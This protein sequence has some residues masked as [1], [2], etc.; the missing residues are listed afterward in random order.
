M[1]NTNKRS[2]SQSAFQSA[3]KDRLSAA[4]SYRSTS[5]AVSDSIRELKERFNV[6]GYCWQ[7]ADGYQAARLD[8]WYRYN[9]CF[10]Y[11]IGGEIVEKGWDAMTEEQRE[12]CR[13]GKNT[14]G[15]HWWK[16][17]EGKPAIGFPFF[18]SED[19]RL[20][21]D[22]VTGHYPLSDVVTERFTRQAQAA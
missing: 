13:A 5:V 20:P 12:Y 7:W 3:V 1:S 22:P 4:E 17:R 14:V 18:V 10:C 6:P 8:A 11:V 19:K 2:R 16:D 15:G 9:L 21:R